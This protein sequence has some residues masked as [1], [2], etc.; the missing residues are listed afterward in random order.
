MSWETPNKVIDSDRPNISKYDVLV[1]PGS[2]DFQ[3][4]EKEMH[5]NTNRTMA[6]H[7]L[8]YD[9]KRTMFETANDQFEGK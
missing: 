6:D 7:R 5:G 1:G 4:P 3:A 8:K 2:S 9:W